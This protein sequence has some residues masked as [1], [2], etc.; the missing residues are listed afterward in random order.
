MDVSTE[1][2]QNSERR[3]PIWPHSTMFWYVSARHR[4]TFTSFFI[5]ALFSMARKRTQCRCSLTDMNQCSLIYTV[6][7]NVLHIHSGNVYMKTRKRRRRQWIRTEYNDENVWK[8]CNEAIS[9]Y[10]N[11]TNGARRKKQGRNIVGTHRHER[12]DVEVREFE[13]NLVLS[14]LL[15][16]GVAT[17]ERFW[18]RV[19]LISILGIEVD[20]FYLVQR[21]KNSSLFLIAC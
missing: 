18:P 7:E 2:P 13:L 10:V 11:L 17:K 9:L 16:T 21:S 20:P 4:D 15:T 8:C 5:A 12:S 14:K 6:E 19:W 3:T 1:V